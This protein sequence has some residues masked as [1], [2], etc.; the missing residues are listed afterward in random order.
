MPKN[1]VCGV[2][3]IPDE[4]NATHLFSKNTRL[5]DHLFR[6]IFIRFHLAIVKFDLL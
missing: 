6:R 5:L 1:W 4:S 3:E 2:A